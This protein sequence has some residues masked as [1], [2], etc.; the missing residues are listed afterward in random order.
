M[1]GRKVLAGLCAAAALLGC[2]SPGPSP[3]TG[4]VLVALPV[5]PFDLEQ[6][7]CGGEALGGP[8]VLTAT[9]GGI[10]GMHAGTKIT[11]RWP[12]GYRAIFDPEFTEVVTESGQVFARASEDVNPSDV[13]RFRGLDHCLSASQLD[14]WRPVPASS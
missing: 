14:F 6:L 12:R 3:A 1:M 11:I 7:S 4:P 2:S 9:P 13:I 8:I 5:S 10:V